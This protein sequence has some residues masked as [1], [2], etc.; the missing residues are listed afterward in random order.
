[1]SPRVISPARYTRYKTE[2]W[3]AEQRRQ[4]KRPLVRNEDIDNSCNA[5]SKR[6][7]R[8]R[9]QPKSEIQPQVCKQAKK[10][11][12][13][14]IA[15]DPVEIGMNNALQLYEHVEQERLQT[16]TSIC[17]RQARERLWLTKIT[18][19]VNQSHPR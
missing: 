4:D 5:H 10:V 17:C 15:R 6:L 12:A 11:I 9:P 1:M 7:D 18:C 19:I 14:S 16:K 2:I 13:R 3:T 8:V